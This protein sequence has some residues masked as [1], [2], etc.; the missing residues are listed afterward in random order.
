MSMSDH[1][2]TFLTRLQQAKRWNVSKRSVERWGEDE[3]LGLPS[4]IEINGRRYRK[5]SELEAW[6]RSRAVSAAR[7]VE[8]K[9]CA[10]KTDTP[11]PT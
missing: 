9:S 10:D 7:H 6:E 3:K 8:R 4:E 1:R 2:E 11:S 5:L